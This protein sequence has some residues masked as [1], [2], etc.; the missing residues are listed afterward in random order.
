[1]FDAVIVKNQLHFFEGSMMLD[2]LE[3][4]MPDSNAFKAS[5]GRSCDPVFEFKA[6]DFAITWR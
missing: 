6:A 5:P 4:S 2:M 3:I 1:M